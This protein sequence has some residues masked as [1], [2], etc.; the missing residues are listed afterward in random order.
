M[1]KSNPSEGAARVLAVAGN[2]AVVQLPGRRFPGVLVQGDTFALLCERL[3][4]ALAGW[5]QRQAADPSAEEAR[6]VAAEFRRLQTFYEQTLGAEGIR[7]P[8]AVRGEPK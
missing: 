1:S 4:D 6:E 2:A 5:L 3:D 8:Y 7:L